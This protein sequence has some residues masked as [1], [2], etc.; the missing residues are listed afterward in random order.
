[1][2][3]C[4]SVCARTCVRARARICVPRKRERAAECQ[5]YLVDVRLGGREDKKKYSCVIYTG[6]KHTKNRR[7]KRKAKNTRLQLAQ[8]PVH[9][10]VVTT[11]TTALW[12]ALMSV[13]NDNSQ[14]NRN[15]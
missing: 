12:G 15:L 6:S 10:H 8:G 4:V 1:M 2:C 9:M 11:A 13:I 14:N 5:I 3:L 7:R